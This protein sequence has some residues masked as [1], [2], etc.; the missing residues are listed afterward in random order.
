MEDRKK[1]IELELLK[2]EV[3]RM[4]RCG[5][6]DG[7]IYSHSINCRCDYLNGRQFALEKE[8]HDMEDSL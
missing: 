3:E 2:I 5:D 8:L 1:S 6:G 4:V 7:K